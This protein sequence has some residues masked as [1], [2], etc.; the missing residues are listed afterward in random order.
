MK[1]AL[2]C[3]CSASAI[4]APML[5]EFLAKYGTTLDKKVY[6]VPKELDIEVARLKARAL[7]AELDVLTLEQEAYLAAAE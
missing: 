3:P 7:G 4:F 5:L 1:S 2:L 6:D